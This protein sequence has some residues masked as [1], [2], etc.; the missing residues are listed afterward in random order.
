MAKA[1][2]KGAPK[3]PNVVT[4]SVR[5]A[6]KR[7]FPFLKLPPELRNEVYKLVLQRHTHTIVDNRLTEHRKVPHILLLNRQ[8]YQEAISVLYGFRDFCVDVPWALETNITNFIRN[9]GSTNAGMIRRLTFQV[10]YCCRDHSA[11]LPQIIENV[12]RAIPKVRMLEEVTLD[13]LNEVDDRL[14]TE[15]SRQLH[16]NKFVRPLLEPLRVFTGLKKLT[17]TGDIPD[18]YAESLRMDMEAKE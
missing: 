17:I 15:L 13:L 3:R 12:S 1:R 9:I 2:S 8:I 4:R 7:I 5:A 11:D 10:H 18:F 16:F 14:P 6:E